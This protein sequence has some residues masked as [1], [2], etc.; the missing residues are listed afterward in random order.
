MMN[1]FNLLLKQLSFSHILL[2]AR[3]YEDPANLNV[4]L[5]EASSLLFL[6]CLSACLPVSPS[7]A[8]LSSALL[9][10]GHGLTHE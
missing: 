5:L 9:A 8:D 10:K 7:L 6:I 1:W 3:T 4:W 2:H